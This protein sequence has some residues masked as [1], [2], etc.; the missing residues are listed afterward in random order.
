MEE[1]TAA[2]VALVPDCFC[3][4]SG[5]T[6]CRAG[7]C[8]AGLGDLGDALAVPVAPQEKPPGILGLCAQKIIECALQLLH[9]GGL[10]RAVLCQR[11]A[12]LQLLIGLRQRGLAL[13]RVMIGIAVERQVARDAHKIG[14]ERARLFRRDGVP[15]AHA[16]VVYALLH[17]ALILQDAARNGAA[18]PA[19]FF[20]HRADGVFY[21][22]VEQLQNLVVAH[23]SRAS[24]RASAAAEALCLCRRKICGMVS[25]G[26]G[27]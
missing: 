9:H 15:C 4:P 5:C 14:L 25:L 11:Q 27:S 10:L 22:V 19:V 16:G 7:A 23:R 13:L 24:C 2:S 26:I 17:V 1:G 3:V 18:E 12:G 21:P 8:A 6:S 20:L